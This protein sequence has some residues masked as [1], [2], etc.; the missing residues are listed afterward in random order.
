[1]CKYYK[2]WY[3]LVLSQKHQ[4]F[5]LFINICFTLQLE[6]EFFMKSVSLLFLKN[7]TGWGYLIAIRKHNF[8]FIH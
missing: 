3:S 5:K 1:M 7:K 8:L 2:V 6:G 4:E